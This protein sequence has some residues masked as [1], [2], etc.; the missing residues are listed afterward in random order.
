MRRG[1]LLAAT[2]LMAL[3]VVAYNLIVVS[4]PGGLD[5]V[6]AYTRLA[7]PLLRLN[8]AAGGE[9]P[10]SS[11]DLLLA[12]SL[13]VLFIELV[14]PAVSRRLSMIN[15]GLTI[16]VFAS[17]LV[18]M[19]LVPACANSLFFLVTLMVLLDILAGF[20]VGMDRE[21]GSDDRPFR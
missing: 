10:V 9:W 19:L 2:P 18:E 8:T 5:S 15:H 16:L 14:K 11:G 1:W 3:P 21:Q 7:S 4:L 13:S 6:D 17:C 12:G 20:M